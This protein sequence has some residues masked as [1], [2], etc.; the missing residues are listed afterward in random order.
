MGPGPRWWPRGSSARR[1]SKR[2]VRSTSGSARGTSWGGRCRWST[3]WPSSSAPP[4][5]AEPRYPH[6][7]PD[8]RRR[9]P[10]VDSLLRSD[11]GRRASERSGRAV[12]RR[13]IRSVLDDAR[14]A[15]RRG[16]E[17]PDEEALLA[18]A[19]ALAARMSSGLTPVINATGVILHT[20]LGRA[21]L[22]EPAVRA[23]ERAARGYT[24]LEV[25]R[26]SGTRGRRTSRA[27]FLLEALTGAEAA[28]VLNNNAAALL[29]AMAALARRRD[30]VVSRGELIEIGGEFRL[31]EIMRASG[32]KLVEVGTTGAGRRARREPRPGRWRRPGVLLRR[33]APG[34]APGRGGPRPGGPDRAI[35][36]PSDRPR[37]A[38]GQDDRGRARD[39]AGDARAGP[40]RRVAGV[41]VPHG[42]SHRP[43]G[44]GAT[45]G[46]IDPRRLG[47]RR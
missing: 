19:V 17:P 9:L 31:P 33:Q 12:V 44:P 15:S 23:V 22:P 32:A 14:A 28:L 29:L 34:R 4:L 35:A 10:S 45:A 46:R 26:E 37:R 47:R 11:P 5:P 7:M 3:W 43:A 6:R 42:A 27:E 16:R 41:A 36:A 2:S 20:N 8:R 40:A 39:G 21:P 38:G 18:L 24:D 25:D 30:V 13:A 1:R